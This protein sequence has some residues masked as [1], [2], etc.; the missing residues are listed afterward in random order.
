MRSILVDS[1]VAGK[2]LD[3]VAL[4]FTKPLTR[5]EVKALIE[6]GKILVNSKVVKAG[7]KLKLNDILAIERP[8]IAKIPQLKLEILYE[9][10][11]CIVINKPS[12]ILTHSKGSYNSEPTVASFIA[13]FFKGMG[14]NRAG[15]VHRL[16]RATSGVII[17]AKNQN[18]LSSLQKQFSLRR[19]TK[20]YIAITANKFK[21]NEA[22]IDMPIERNPHRP[23]TFRT[24]LGGKPAITKF[25]VT[26]S[27][28][29]GGSAF[30]KVVLTPQTGRTHQ[31][32]VHLAKIGHPIVGDTLYGGIPYERLMLHAKSLEITLPSG[33]RRR[34]ESA[35][36]IIFKQFEAK[37]KNA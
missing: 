28:A 12:G 27:F 16:D 33:E 15:I 35:L 2:R 1:K 25:V 29:V 4:G 6:N 22:I 31:L 37:F 8:K 20:T 32:R 10:N 3:I 21:N 26:N 19:A 24:G 23:Q 34:F 9:D 30:S 17:C 13:P 36:P 5:S 14:G 7:Y 18:A 11:D